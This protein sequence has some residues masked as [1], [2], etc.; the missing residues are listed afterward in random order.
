MF[1]I[2]CPPWTDART[3]L[4]HLHSEASTKRI[5]AVRVV[6]Q[7]ELLSTAQ[8]EVTTD[9][10]LKSA[11]ITTNNRINAGKDLTVFKQGN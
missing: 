6:L 8:V 9:A 7:G 1:G 2:T 3:I 11:R 4:L 10:N 5:A